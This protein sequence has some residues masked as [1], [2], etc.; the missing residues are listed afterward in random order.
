MV[1]VWLLI[2]LL[3]MALVKSS[4]LRCLGALVCSCST[5]VGDAVT[6]VEERATV[7][8]AVSYTHLTLPTILRV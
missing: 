8:L 3:E 6:D 4:W 7:V 2:F 1:N 5:G